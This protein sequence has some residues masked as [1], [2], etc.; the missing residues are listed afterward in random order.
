MA[1]PDHLAQRPTR[2]EQVDPRPERK[3]A[4]GIRGSADPA[5]LSAKV[6][7]IERTAGEVSS[8]EADIRTL[9]DALHDPDLYARD[10]GQVR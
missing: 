4:K 2:P 5:R 3:V 1:I 10:P 6:K 9:E 8:M 7:R